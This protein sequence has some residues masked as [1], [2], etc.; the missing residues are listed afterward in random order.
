[1]GLRV[2]HLGGIQRAAAAALGRPGAST[3]IVPTLVDVEDAVRMA[4][5]LFN[6]RVG[7]AAVAVDLFP[8]M[9]NQSNELDANKT[10]LRATFFLLRG[11]LT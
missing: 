9:V 4:S 1:V 5:G 11:P 3:G 10:L 2:R 6:E 8:P 7:A